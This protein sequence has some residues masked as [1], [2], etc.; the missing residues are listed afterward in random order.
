LILCRLFGATD[1][2]SLISTVA[3]RA[4]LKRGLTVQLLNHAK[5]FRMKKIFL[6]SI[7]SLTLAVSVA[8]ASYTRASQNRDAASLTGVW[9][10]NF[11]ETAV[12]AAEITLNI[13]AG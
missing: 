4:E 10:G 9:K 2:A 8:V 5:E 3:L 11:P 6:L 13:Q 1:V 7:L 12:P